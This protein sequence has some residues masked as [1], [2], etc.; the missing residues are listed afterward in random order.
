MNKYLTACC[1]TLLLFCNA[2][3]TNTGAKGLLRCTNSGKGK[4]YIASSAAWQQKRVQ[5]LDSMQA[6]M[7]KLPSFSNL[8]DFDL[9]TTDSLQG[10]GYTRY[11]ISFLVALNERL[12]AYLYIPNKTSY[13]GPLPAMLALHETDSIGKKSVDGQ[14]HNPNLGYAKE[15]AQR[16]YIVIA[17]DYPGFGD[18]KSFDFSNSRY[19]S[20]TMKSIFDDMRCVDLLLARVDVDTGRIGIIGHSLGGHSALFAAAFDTRLKVVVSSCGWTLFDAYNI[21]DA[22]AKIYGGRL[23]PWAQARYMP[24]LRTK[25]KLDPASFPF[26]FDGVMAA[27]A[28]RGC[29]SISPLK[30]GNFSVMGVKQGIKNAAAVYHL[31]KADQLLR[32]IYPDAEHDFPVQAREAAYVFIDK[33][34][35]HN[36]VTNSDK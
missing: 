13:Q 23:G 31:L 28:P 33:I 22:A 32:C 19:Q 9:K 21:G 12:W 10:I 26:D 34:L 20:G 36:P 15:L 14:G 2:C 24:L 27:I 8:P 11:T 29:F 16:G 3:R 17:P 6:G 30:D 35:H 18:L 4:S 7:G 25:Y 1:Y 5:L